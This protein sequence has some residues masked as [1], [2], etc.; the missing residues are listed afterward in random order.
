MELLKASNILRS[1]I[2]QCLNADQ[3]SIEIETQ[4]ERLS[5]DPPDMEDLCEFFENVLPKLTEQFIVIDGIDEF[6]TMERDS[7]L[8]VLRSLMKSS[9]VKIFLASGP[10]IEA[11][12]L[13]RKLKPDHRVSLTSEHVNS[14]IQTYIEDVIAEKKETGEL[15][16]GQQQLLTEIKSALLDGAQGM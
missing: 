4:L 14:D 10:H 1:L 16:V 15:I 12:L 9:S 5:L 3:L 6:K 13:K 7:L 8:S 11:E 2:R